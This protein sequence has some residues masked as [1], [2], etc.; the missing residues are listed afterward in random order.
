[1]NSQVNFLTII[2]NKFLLYAGPG[3][4]SAFPGAVSDT[5][6]GTVQGIRSG[7]SGFLTWS[8][9]SFASHLD[10]LLEDAPNA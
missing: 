2:R 7:F 3:K 4:K 10:E 9:S 1:M 8:W 6:T 5:D